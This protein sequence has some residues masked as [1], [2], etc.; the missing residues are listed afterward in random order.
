MDATDKQ[1]HL[2]VD[3]YPQISPDLQRKPPPKPKSKK[4][5]EIGDEVEVVLRPGSS[6]NRRRPPKKEREQ[7]ER[8]VR[9]PDPERE[10]RERNART[11]DPVSRVDSGFE[12]NDSSIPFE[13]PCPVLERPPTPRQARAPSPEDRPLVVPLPPP[14]LPDII[15]PSQ[16]QQ[17]NSNIYENKPDQTFSCAELT[18]PPIPERP[19]S[20]QIDTLNMSS[21]LSTPHA[22]LFLKLWSHLQFRNDHM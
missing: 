10:P 12:D 8:N 20:M 4:S 14:R 6:S 9:T 3:Q 15:S 19:S 21:M 13:R 7:R 2:P 22:K 1:L 18:P 16:N 17:L 5:D 11:P